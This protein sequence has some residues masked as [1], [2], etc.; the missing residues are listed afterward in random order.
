[1]AGT[2]ADFEK[3]AEVGTEVDSGQLA[4]AGTVAVLIAGA[5]ATI[6]MICFVSLVG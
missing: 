4:G 5:V 1:M 3:L 2:E 6:K